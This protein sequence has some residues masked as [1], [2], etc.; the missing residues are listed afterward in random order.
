MHLD[1]H[2]DAR[3]SQRAKDLNDFCELRA[4]PSNQ[5]TS[6][7]SVGITVFKIISII[8]SI[9]LSLI[10]GMTLPPPVAVITI[11]LLAMVT[12]AIVIGSEKIGRLFPRSIWIW[13][14]HSS[15]EPLQYYQAMPS[16]SNRGRARGLRR[17]IPYFGRSSPSFKKMD[18]YSQPATVSHSETGTRHVSVGGRMPPPFIGRAGN[19]NP[20]AA[21]VASPIAAGT[22][23][24]AIGG[25]HVD[26]P[27]VTDDGNMGVGAGHD[28]RQPTSSG[29]V[30]P[31][32]RK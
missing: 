9:F 3:Y 4:V 11:T 31:G 17:F 28:R 19:A 5:I 8:T 27:Y 1:L 7:N 24:V 23:N 20:G 14:T 30:I 29:Q 16:P 25:Q 26:S 15:P 10:A 2:T 22:H 32:S 6:Q 21:R 12:M 13:N 18:S